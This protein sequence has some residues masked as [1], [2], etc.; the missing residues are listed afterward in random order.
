VL[1]ATLW[2]GYDE[3]GCVKEAASRGGR[4][5]FFS[6]CFVNLFWGKIKLL[7]K[8]MLMK[9]EIDQSG[10]IEN[11][12]RLTVVAYANGY[13]KS[14]VITAKDKKSI[15]SIFRK[16]NQPRV[17]ISKVF[18]AA[19]LLLIASDYKKIDTIVID[20][21]YPGHERIIK[22][23]LEEY[24]DQSGLK[25]E[26]VNIYFRN[27]GRKSEAHSAAYKA[28]RSKKADI[29]ATAKDILQVIFK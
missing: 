4:A 5:T 9:I 15:Q 1:G 29:K 27:I 23:Y 13:T 17:F 8:R 21:E 20:N 3:R 25:S 14:L 16:I 6:D 19:I 28:F 12:N 24:I 22:E 7:Y 10:K 26:K 2:V 11:T 18:A